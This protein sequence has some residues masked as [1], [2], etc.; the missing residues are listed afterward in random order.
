MSLLSPSRILPSNREEKPQRTSLI[1]QLHMYK[2]QCGIIICLPWI[3]L[4]EVSR[5]PTSL[6]YLRL[7]GT[8]CDAVLLAAQSLCLPCELKHCNWQQPPRL[9]WGKK[10]HGQGSNPSWSRQATHTLIR[11][12]TH[13]EK[14]NKCGPSLLI[15]CWSAVTKW[16]RKLLVA[17]YEEGP[18]KRFSPPT[19]TSSSWHS[20]AS[21]MAARFPL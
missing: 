14:K 3:V 4:L 12:H 21:R 18:Q 7:D 13:G 2:R 1:T 16:L 5:R 17:G 9:W 19:P 15:K 6:V 10:Q 20:A 8:Q 11:T